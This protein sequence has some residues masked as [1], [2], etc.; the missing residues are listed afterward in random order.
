MILVPFVTRG[1]LMVK[2]ASK[3]AGKCRRQWPARREVMK[4]MRPMFE[5]FSPERNEK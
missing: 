2:I 1:S 4:I 5:S 3:V